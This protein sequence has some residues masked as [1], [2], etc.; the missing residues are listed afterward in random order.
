MSGV[1]AYLD[2]TL[3]EMGVA[4]WYEARGEARGV[5]KGEARGVVKG[6][7]RKAFDIAKNMVKLG[8]PL[9]T[10]VSA[11]SVDPKKIKAMYKKP[12]KAVTNNKK[13]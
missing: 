8:L 13:R 4:A 1:I 3:T 12:V 9:E 10:V 6:E 2:K 5:V 11:T 7:E